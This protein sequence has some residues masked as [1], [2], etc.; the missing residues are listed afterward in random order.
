MPRQIKVGVL[1]PYSTIYPS[2]GQDLQEGI[3]C[4]LSDKLH[5]QIQFVSEFIHQGQP[6]AIKPALEKLFMFEQV[7]MVT[8]LVGYRS[9]VES[10]PLIEQTKKLALFADMGEYIPFDELTSQY[11]FFNSFQYW[12]AEFA[13]GQWAQQSFGGKGA[14]LMPIYDGGYH[15]HTAFRHGTLMAG[16]QGMEYATIH[17]DQQENYSVRDAIQEYLDK[18]KKERPDYL[19]ALFCGGEAKDFFELYHQSG[20]H[21]EVPLVV[22]PHMASYE[23]LKDVE[24]LD[25]TFHAASLWNLQADDIANTRF[26]QRYIDRMGMMPTIFLI[27]RIRNWAGIGTNS[28]STRNKRFCRRPRKF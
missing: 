8:G 23:I 26:R 11:L 24:N 18:F 7:D 5:L 25:M 4:G 10:L 15:M 13:L 27:I 17:F 9:I 14:I 1:I 19:H 22:S 6:S 21:K 3:W 28:R 12:Q 20:L 2:L 16:N